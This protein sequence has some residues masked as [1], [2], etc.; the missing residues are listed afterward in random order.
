MH[1]AISVFTLSPHSVGYILATSQPWKTNLGALFDINWGLWPFLPF[2]ITFYCLAMAF[3]G[4]P[5]KIL[6]Y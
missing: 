3:S 4:C 2:S 6:M 5:C 1:F